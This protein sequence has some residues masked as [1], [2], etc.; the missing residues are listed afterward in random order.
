MAP[1]KRPSETTKWLAAILTSILIAIFFEIAIFNYQSLETLTAP[2][3]IAQINDSDPGCAISLDFSSEE[4]C[5]LPAS[6][7]LTTLTLRTDSPEELQFQISITD[8]GNQTPYE[9]GRIAVSG[10]KTI[11]VN[12]SGKIRSI[13]VRCPENAS[14]QNVITVSANDPIPFDIS[15]RRLIAIAVICLIVF[16]VGTSSP[17]SR[18]QFDANAS[19]RIFIFSASAIF[20]VSLCA[21]SAVSLDTPGYSHHHQYFELAQALVAGHTSLLI[22]PSPELLALDNPYDTTARIASGAPYLWDHAFFNGH[23]YVYFGVLPALLYYVPFYLLTSGGE[24]PNWI[25]VA[26]SYTLFAGGLLYLLSNCCKK[27]FPRTSQSTFLIAYATLLMGSCATNGAQC[28]DLYTVPISLGLACAAWGLAF[29]VKSITTSTVN[30]AFACLGAFLLAL[31]SLCRPQLLLFG[32]VGI[33]LALQHLQNHPAIRKSNLKPIAIACI[34]TFVVFAAAAAYNTSRFGSPLDFGANYNLTTN[35]M[36]HRGWNVDRLPLAY[37]AYLFEP[38]A[39]SLD[40]LRFVPV[41]LDYAYYGTTISQTMI[42]GF[43]SLLPIVTL[44]IIIALVTPRHSISDPW[45]PLAVVLILCGFFLVAF[46]A[47][48]AGILM[49]YFSD[50]GT[51][52]ALAS[53]LALL[54]LLETIDNRLLSNGTTKEA[55]RSD[56]AL[57]T[58][59]RRFIVLTLAATIALFS[60]QLM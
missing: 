47:N 39:I 5:S 34:P 48:G 30:T 1:L 43:F 19:F 50:F 55:M 57:A 23:Y 42:G 6:G 56:I 22:D 27:W 4:E 3:K 28:P 37:Y 52:L 20:L 60:I 8:E 33:A 7:N 58:G 9:I 13:Q 31:T 11:K 14:S 17:L 38:F 29:L 59:V 24:L 25:A 54:S 35:D 40:N 45:K 41:N 2:K 21:A 15:K 49:R 53:C 16:A 51:M 10:Q 32:I 46:D 26:I 44:G 12:P 36:T 18:K